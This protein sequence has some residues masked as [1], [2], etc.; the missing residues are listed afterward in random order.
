MK[1]L[2]TMSTKPRINKRPP[3]VDEIAFANGNFTFEVAFRGFNTEVRLV[4]KEGIVYFGEAVLSFKDLNTFNRRKGT[5]KAFKQMLNGSEI[6]ISD[7][8]KS[9]IVEFIFLNI[10]D[11]IYDFAKEARK[12]SFMNNF[13][14]LSRPFYF[15]DLN[16]NASK[17]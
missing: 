2:M 3:V 11:K 9:E 5:L 13:R 14:K 1:T 17:A 6:P 8:E 15:M 12:A 4:T 7:D 16:G 10:P